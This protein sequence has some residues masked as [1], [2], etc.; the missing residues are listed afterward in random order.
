[1]TRGRHEQPQ[2]TERL[3]GRATRASRWTWRKVRGED[4]YNLVILV[5]AVTVLNIGIA[6]ALPVWSHF[7]RR[8]MEEELI[9]RGLQY[10]EAIRLFQ[11]RNGRLPVKLEELIKVEPRCIRQLYPNP[12]SKSGK[13][14]KIYDTGRGGRR[15]GPGVRPE[16][17]Q[18]QQQA[19]NEE[20]EGAPRV[21]QNG[22][23]LAGGR[24]GETITGPIRGVYSPEGDETVKTWFGSNS[25][26]DWQ[27]TFDI[28]QAQQPTG[29]P[30]NPNAPTQSMPVNSGRLGRP[31]PPGVQQMPG[32]LQGGGNRGPGSQLDG[33]GGGRDVGG[34][35]TPP[36]DTPPT[37]GGDD[38]EN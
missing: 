28:L 17:Q 1:M 11:M 7:N 30:N 22:D 25:V 3:P 5:V 32:G 29:N 27:F 38:N 18:Q 8:E 21:N 12:M 36:V 14:G 2:V 15:D 10:A 33:G 23:L 26:R 6:A 4:G 19:Q 20:D 24:E 34:G 37:F 9:F 16:F 31:L 13:W 35:Q